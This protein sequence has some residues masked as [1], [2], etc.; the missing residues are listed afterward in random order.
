MRVQYVQTPSCGAPPNYQVHTGEFDNTLYQ[1]DW[2]LINRTNPEYI[3]TTGDTETL[4]KIIC[5]FSDSKFGAVERQFLP[6]PLSAKFYEL[7]QLSMNYLLKK[8]TKLQ[9]QLKQKDQEIEYLRHKLEKS[10]ETIP[11]FVGRDV[12]VVHSCPVCNKAFKSFYHLDKHVKKYH[13]N[14]LDAWNSLR[15]NQ[16]YGAKFE[17][18]E[19]QHEINHLRECITR[20]EYFARVEPQNP[21]EMFPGKANA[22]KKPSGNGGE[23]RITEST[24]VQPRAFRSDFLDFED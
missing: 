7:I 10:Y 21:P 4:E 15:N 11:K 5:S 14:L 17:F 6:F 24:G 8:Q 19:L 1:L 20:Q 18:Q 13:L 9:Q 23:G 22:K 2:N 12:S 16:P 3:R